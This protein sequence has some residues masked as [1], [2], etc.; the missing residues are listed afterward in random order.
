MLQKLNDFYQDYAVLVCAG[1]ALPEDEKVMSLLREASCICAADGGW[2]LLKRLRIRP[3]ILLGDFD[4]SKDQLKEKKEWIEQNGI[5]FQQFPVRKNATDSELGLETLFQKNYRR[6]LLLGGM[7]SRMDHSI[8]NF[9]MLRTYAILGMD[10]RLWTRYNRICFL[11]AGQY[12]A[13]KLDSSVYSSLLTVDEG[14]FIG[15]EGFDYP[16]N[17][18]R[19]PVGTS[20]GISNHV[21]SPQNQIEVFA[22]ENQGVFYFESRDA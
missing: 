4:S 18:Q 2:D 20:L 6:V 5:E 17:K 11:K 22:K 1:S 19:L 15:L 8:C 14:I 12:Q 9:L 10:V 7:G 13:P 21:L 3:N 16:L